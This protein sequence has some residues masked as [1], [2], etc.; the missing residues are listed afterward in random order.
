MLDHNISSNIR[1]KKT[2]PTEVNLL[3][4]STGL[5]DT[6]YSQ[7]FGKFF[8]NKNKDRINPVDSPVKTNKYS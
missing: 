2:F 5:T 7:P 3:K 1:V 6:R 4:T 8:L